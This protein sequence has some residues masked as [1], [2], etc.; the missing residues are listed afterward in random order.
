MVQPGSK[1]PAPQS[2]PLGKCLHHPRSQGSETAISYS[3]ALTYPRGVC[4]QV[5]RTRCDPLERPDLHPFTPGSPSS[6][7][8]L[9]VQRI[10]EVS[11]LKSDTQGLNTPSLV[12]RVQK[13]PWL[14]KPE[15]SGTLPL[16]HIYLKNVSASSYLSTRAHAYLGKKKL[17]SL[18]AGM[19]VT[20]LPHSHLMPRCEVHCVFYF[21]PQ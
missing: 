12:F 17:G 21:N 6:S 9:T 1:S 7:Q 10:A 16:P 11:S 18:N 15:V 5:V 19:G 3:L 8:R 13:S 14:Q 2:N 20:C 4:K